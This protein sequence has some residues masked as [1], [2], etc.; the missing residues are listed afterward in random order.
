MTHSGRNTLETT[1]QRP[2]LVK[3]A[4]LFCSVRRLIL[5]AVKKKKKTAVENGF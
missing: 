2:D 5:K 1:E 3:L 4:S